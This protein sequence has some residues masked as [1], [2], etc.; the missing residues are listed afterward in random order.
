MHYFCDRLDD[1]NH[2]LAAIAASIV[3]G[4][5]E[6]VHVAVEAEEDGVFYA[7]PIDLCYINYEQANPVGGCR[8]EY[9][10]IDKAL[11]VRSANCSDAQMALRALR[12]AIE[13]EKT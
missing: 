4:E 9:F 13:C 8:L 3:P 12:K 6:L 2:I 11:D 5:Q 7:I 1:A 10:I